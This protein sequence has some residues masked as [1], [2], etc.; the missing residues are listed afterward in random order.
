MRAN[1]FAIATAKCSN[2]ICGRLEITMENKK[3]VYADNAATTRV[4]DEVFEAMRPFYT[5]MYGNASTIYSFG[6]TSKS[7]LDKARVQVA[8]AIGAQPA[9]I[10]FTSCGTESDNW[11]IFGTIE[12]QS[13]KGKHLI[14]TPFEHHAVLHP[15]QELEK[16]GYE[17]TY[18]KLDSDGLIDLEELKQAIRPDTVLVTIMFANNEIGTVQDIPAIGKICRDAGVTFHTDAVQAIGHVKVDVIEQNIDLLSLSAHKFHGPKGIGA[19]YIRRGTRISNLMH[20]G[21]Q[22]RKKRP[23]TENI[24]QIVGLGKAIETAVGNLDAESARVTKLRDKLIAGI[25][26]RISDV[27]LNGHPTK[28]LPGNVNMSMK[29]IEG[30]SLLMMLDYHGI[31]ASSGSACTTGALDPSHVLMSI[32]LDHETAHGSLR[33]SFAEFSTEEDVDYILEKLPPIVEKLRAMSPLVK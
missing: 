33:F 2:K 14:S 10:F 1:H 17:V 19:L 32:G 13:S 18:L 21:G 5:E 9:E 15:L 6:N 3:I 4:S 31:C 28:R 25:T 12:A 22:E 8:Q 24:A 29:F 7:A 11:A 20:G 27:K 23:G 26:E 30:E 16:K